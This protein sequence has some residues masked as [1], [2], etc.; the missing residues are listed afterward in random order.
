MADPISMVAIG[1]T[2]AGGVV[3]GIGAANTASANAAAYNYKAGIATLNSQIAQQN[4]SWAVQSGGIK[5]EEEGLQAGQAIGQ[6]K[7]AQSAGGFDVNTGSN[8]AVRS[9]QSDVAKFNEGIIT[10][11]AARKAYGYQVEGAKD[12]AEATM[13]TSAASNAKTAGDLAVLSSILGTVGSVAGKW[14]Q[15]NT[16]GI[17]S[18]SSSGGGIDSSGNPSWGN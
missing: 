12:T 17:G 5:S 18:S 14:T 1:S 16:I 2:I 4:A 7:V 15:G 9:T 6:T 8:S 3:S 10:T 11:D 13:D